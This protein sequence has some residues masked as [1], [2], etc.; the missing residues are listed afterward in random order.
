MEHRPMQ[1][2]ALQVDIITELAVVAETVEYR[3]LN[4]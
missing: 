1:G 4:G 3:P 2:L